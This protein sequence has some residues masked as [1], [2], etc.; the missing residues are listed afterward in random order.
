MRWD[1]YQETT[2]LSKT[3]SLLH[4]THLKV[5]P[6]LVPR[7]KAVCCHSRLRP[8]ARRVKQVGEKGASPGARS[9]SIQRPS[10]LFT[11]DFD[12][13]EIAAQVL[14]L[15]IE[16]HSVAVGLR[17]KADCLEDLLRRRILSG[18]PEVYP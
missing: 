13:D 11:H 7:S 4:R 18:C 5:S 14:L 3:S 1:N 8:I 10:V 6:L 17:F 16:H 12:K 9:R 15:Q 2:I